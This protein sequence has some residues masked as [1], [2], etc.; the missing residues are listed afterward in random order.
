MPLQIHRAPVLTLWTTVVAE[1][2]GH[3]VDTTLDP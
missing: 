3:S 2:L 1:Q